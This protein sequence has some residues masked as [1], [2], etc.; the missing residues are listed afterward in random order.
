MLTS[1]SHAFFYQA[2]L[3]LVLIPDLSFSKL[4]KPQS[5]EDALSSSFP[6]DHTPVTP[7]DSH[8]TASDQTIDVNWDNNNEAG[9]QTSSNPLID[10]TESPLIADENVDCA[11]LASR[12]RRLRLDKRQK[13]F[14]P[15]QEFRDPTSPTPPEE[16]KQGASSPTDLDGFWPKLD[17]KT[18]IYRLLIQLERAPGT[19]G[20]SNSKVCE[21]TA[22][23]TS[24]VCFPFRLNYP[25][26]IRSPANLVEPCRFRK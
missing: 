16:G 13:S 17:K 6:P 7:F 14:C 19:N 8:L 24:P 11:K 12:L 23:R 22:G 25:L 10:N 2:E 9:L 26:V 5:Q 20:E 4:G 18:S 3:S 21:G 1:T 15:S